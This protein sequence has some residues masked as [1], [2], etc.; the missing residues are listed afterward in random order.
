MEER[1]A[2]AEMKDRLRIALV[3]GSP[4][5][6]SPVQSREYFA[7]LMEGAVNRLGEAAPPDVWVLPEMFTTGFTMNARLVAEPAEGG[8]TLQWMREV[9]RRYGGVVVGSWVVEDSGRFYNRLHWVYPT[10]EM[11]TYDKAHLFVLTDEPRVYTAGGS[12]VLVVW[13][14]WTF[15]LTIC[16]DLRF[17]YW[18][19]FPGMYEVGVVVASWPARRM[20][21]WRTL[22]QARAIENQVYMVG[23]NRVGR[24]PAETYTGH[25]MAVSFDGTVLVEGTDEQVY[26]VELDREALRVFRRRF[27][28]LR[29]VRMY[30]F[31][32]K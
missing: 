27:P 15:L 12:R 28:M 4:R 1:R 2:N 13:R 6:E 25:S 8:E 30:F 21:A 7:E 32:E 24:D 18:Y 23:V 16:F 19:W 3:Q 9:A 5:W 26:F 29:G 11:V 17:P 14:G 31:Q 20:H 10:G 22:L